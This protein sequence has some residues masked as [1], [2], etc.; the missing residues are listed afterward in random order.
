M[1]RTAAIATYMA[2]P[3]RASQ[4]SCFGY[5]RACWLAA[6]LIDIQQL[7]RFGGSRFPSESAHI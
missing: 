5:R 2:G 3:A 4:S 1:E 6:R 7:T